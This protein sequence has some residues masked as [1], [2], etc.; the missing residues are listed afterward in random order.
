MYTT[1]NNYLMIDNIRCTI[2]NLNTRYS[3]GDTP[4]CTYISHGI[5]YM[6]THVYI[7]DPFTYPA[8]IP[9]QCLYISTDAAAPAYINIKHD[10]NTLTQ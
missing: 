4:V 8:L 6:H 10:Y 5:L 3:K 7:Q 2:K 9:I 1:Y